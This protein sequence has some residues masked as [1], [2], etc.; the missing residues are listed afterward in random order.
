MLRLL[1][2]AGLGPLLR[3]GLFAAAGLALGVAGFAA[4]LR[5]LARTP[6]F[7]PTPLPVPTHDRGRNAKGGRLKRR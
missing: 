4:L 6:A 7:V 3:W 5:G 1:S 2:L